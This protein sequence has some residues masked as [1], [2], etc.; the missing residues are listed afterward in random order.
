MKTILDA[1][2]S[3]MIAYSPELQKFLFSVYDDSYP[4]KIYRNSANLIGGNPRPDDKGPEN[5]LLREITDEINPNH[6]LKKKFIIGE[7]A[8]APEQEIQFIRNS[9]IQFTPFQDFL[10]N[11]EE[12]IE[13]GN[14]PYKAI[15]SVFYSEIPKE[16]I[17]IAEKNLAAK[18]EIASE[19]NLGVFSL[20][21]LTTSSRGEFSTAHITAHILNWKY[22][23]HIPQTKLIHAEA[24]G[25]PRKNYKDYL[26]NFD[27]NPERMVLATLAKN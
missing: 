23:S 26:Q 6:E 17:E 7:V 2:P 8:W 9:L 16:A 18:K 15:Y 20:E 11:Q 25:F 24:I 19:G 10:A 22:S 4:R 12:K 3:V 13:G 27:Y 21:Q 5:T 14:K 1:H